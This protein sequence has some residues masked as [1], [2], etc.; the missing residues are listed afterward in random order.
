MQCRDSKSG[1]SLG[2]TNLKRGDHSRA[3]ST[4]LVVTLHRQFQL[5]FV[6]I[7]IWV[8]THLGKRQLKPILVI[9]QYIDLSP[10]VCPR[11]GTLSP[12]DMSVNRTKLNRQIYFC[13]SRFSALNQTNPLQPTMQP[14]VF[15]CVSDSSSE[16]I[17]TLEPRLGQNARRR[18]REL[19]SQFLCIV[20]LYLSCNIT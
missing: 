8:F 13:S 5:G 15:G 18:E 11:G 9:F 10:A 12:Y 17:W 7:I 3:H 2:W 16:A 19:V 6:M 14:I 1:E 20:R 4:Q